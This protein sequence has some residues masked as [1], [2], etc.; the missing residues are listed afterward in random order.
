MQLTKNFHLDEFKC[1]DGTPVP[2]NLLCN[3]QKLA[4]NLQIIR[5]AV[6][7]PL[8]ITSGYRTPT[9]NKKIGGASD[10][11]HK[12]AKAAD[13]TTK[14]LSPKQLHTLIEKLIK[15]GKVHDGGLGLYKGFVHYDVRPKPARWNG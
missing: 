12:L 11:Q 4:E 2:D 9:Y 7:A 15:Q 1:K 3:V 6:G 14:N 10:S 5:D 13:I 8:P